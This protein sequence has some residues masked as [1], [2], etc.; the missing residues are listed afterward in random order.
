MALTTLWLRLELRRRRASLAVLAVLIALAT[1]TVLTAAA[2]SRR[3]ASVIERMAAATKPATAA[4]YSNTPGFDWS[5]LRRFPEV[6]A[7]S[8]FL[9]DYTY[10]YRGLS[11]SVIDGGFPPLDD[12]NLHSIETPVVFK[13][14]MFDPRRADEAVVTRGF[15]DAW[16]KSVGDTVVLELPTTAEL[17]AGSG[18]GPNGE[19]TGPHPELTIVGVIGSLWFSDQ[20]GGQGLVLMS[21]GVVKRYSANLLGPDNRRNLYNFASAMV[22]L[23]GGEAQLAQFQAHLSQRFGR[24]DLEVENITSEWRDAQHLL[25]FE[26]RCLLAFGGAALLAALFL[27]GEAVARYVS[28]AARELH[29]LGAVGVTPRQAVVAATLPVLCV[30]VLGCVLGV[31]GAYVA[32]GWFPIGGARLLEPDPGR[33]P[34]WLVFG[35]GLLAG[36][37]LAATGAAFL[38]WRLRAGRAEPTPRRSAVAALARRLSLPVPF[39]VGARFAF[40]S[41]RGTTAV[42]VRPA[43]IGAVGGVLGVFAAFTFAAGVND[44]IAHPARFGQT[45]DLTAF[46][47]ANGEDFVPAGKIIPAVTSNR[48]IVAVNDARQSI[49]TSPGHAGTFVLYS[50]SGGPKPAHMVLIDGAMPQLPQD[51]V[52]APRM[53]SKLGL[54]VDDRV[55]LRGDRG[56]REFRVTAIGLVPNGPRNGY[57][58]GGWLLAAGYDSIF[59]GFKFHLVQATVRPGADV[60]AVSKALGN[61]IAAAV[62]QAAG[63][64]LTPPDPPVE[65]SMIR[66]VR[67]LPI[68]LG[69]FLAVLALGVIGHAV[70]TAVRRR[71]RD[72]AILRALGMTQRQSAG[73]VATHATL[74]AVIGLVAGVPLGL[75]FGRTVWRAVA[76]TTPLAYEPPW[77][78][79]TL[80]ILV[81]SAI[82]LANVLAALP[83]RSAARL[84]T[85]QLLRA[86]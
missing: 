26:A 56:T 1:G 81:P 70:G 5:A 54:S 32:S 44:A 59:R 20:P 39:V 48:D 30:A 76:D 23:R 72:L 71:S 45:Y 80:L 10:A 4:V 9:T 55:T 61:T 29:A 77:A 47:G 18:S 65:I 13:G 6:A 42:P 22:R 62:P 84:P 25:S 49:A 24:A 40:E 16:H 74:I 67:G 50:Y 53:A 35:L 85:A 86:E 27:I 60:A 31:I 33:S 28:A 38:A 52:V 7:L 63:Y 82:V 46:L 66:S 19:Y 58:E 21:P 75:A 79:V 69:A 43:L 11:D 15:V 3:D 41:G 2:G 37:V 68:A 14:R 57:A 78:G 8:T 34:D 36:T 73:V 51:V 12:G 83:A 17:A 64:T